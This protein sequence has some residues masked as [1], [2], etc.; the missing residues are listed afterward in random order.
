MCK[1]SLDCKVIKILQYVKFLM[2]FDGWIC[3]EATRNELKI[4][5][6][7][8]F[9]I[10][11][12]TFSDTSCA[13]KLVITMVIKNGTK[14]VHDIWLGLGW[15]IN[16]SFGIIDVADLLYCLAF[17]TQK[18]LV[19]V[20]WKMAPPHFSRSCAFRLV[21][22]IWSFK[23]E[24][25]PLTIYDLVQ[26]HKLISLLAQ[27]TYHLLYK[28]ALLFPMVIQNGI[29]FMSWYMTWSQIHW[30]FGITDVVH[31]LYWLALFYHRENV[32]LDW[33]GD[34]FPYFPLW[35]ALTLA[36]FY[37]REWLLRLNGH[38]TMTHLKRL[39]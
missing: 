10:I 28:L 9:A 33:M 29:K 27:L 13:L 12:S 38:R 26:V 15:Q 37:T 7:I 34:G 11:W 30:S 31:L 17:F 32:D 19:E 35:C 23:M 1:D 3:E 21:I 20:E 5:K 39:V 25:C 8:L 4:E 22:T 2:S 24:Q 36:I 14:F 18:R 16:W 6:Q